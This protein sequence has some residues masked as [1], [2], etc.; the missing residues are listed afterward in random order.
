MVRACVDRLRA[1][2]VLGVPEE[3]E[4]PGRAGPVP[5]VGE[6]DRRGV[7]VG[8]RCSGHLPCPEQSG[9]GLT[10]EEVRPDHVTLGLDHHDRDVEVV[11]DRSRGRERDR[12]ERGLADRGARGAATVDEEAVVDVFQ[13]L[14]RVD[15]GDQPARRLRLPRRD[16]PGGREPSEQGRGVVADPGAGGGEDV[17]GVAVARV[18]E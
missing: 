15:V 9:V 6:A 12:C 11:A 5:G 14:H 18:D 8:V 4:H 13:R 16:D 17:V 2:E 10:G 7:R 1:G 3:P